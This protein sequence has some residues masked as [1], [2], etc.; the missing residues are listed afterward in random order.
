MEQLK[1]Y[2]RDLGV[3]FGFLRKFYHRRIRL[4][5]LPQYPTGSDLKDFRYKF[6]ISSCCSPDEYQSQWVV[7]FS[8]YFQFQNHIITDNLTHVLRVIPHDTRFLLLHTKD[9]KL[10]TR[11]LLV[12][13]RHAKLRE[14]PR[15]LVVVETENSISKKNVTRIFSSV[16]PCV[17]FTFLIVKRSDQTQALMLRIVDLLKRYNNR[18][19]LW[20][21]NKQLQNSILVTSNHMDTERTFF[22][23]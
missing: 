10:N 11:D 15:V 18:L 16:K 13:T 6:I 12:L 1:R 23:V 7:Y 4:Q 19:S 9:R 21:L 3:Q 22:C 8:K 17:N 2:T 5:D 20:S 14:I